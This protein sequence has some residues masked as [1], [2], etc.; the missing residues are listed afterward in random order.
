MNNELLDIDIILKNKTVS[1]SI[2]ENKDEVNFYRFNDLISLQNQNVTVPGILI[3]KIVQHVKTKIN[4]NKAIFKDVYFV[5]HINTQKEFMPGYIDK[6]KDILLTFMIQLT[7]SDVKY[8]IDNEII[9]LS[10]CDGI[11]LNPKKQQCQVVLSEDKEDF[12]RVLFFNFLI[13]DG[14]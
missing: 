10:K 11:L 3:N 4:S 8:S 14:N 12:A 1:K 9:T 13:K 2:L 7:P 5:K 6:N